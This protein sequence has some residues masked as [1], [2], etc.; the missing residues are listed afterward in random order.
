MLILLTILASCI[1]KVSALE[2]EVNVLDGPDGHG[3][4]VGDDKGAHLLRLAVADAWPRPTG[5][6][7]R[8]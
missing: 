1:H 2:S 7:Q 5:N 4:E 6:R 3:G 8:A